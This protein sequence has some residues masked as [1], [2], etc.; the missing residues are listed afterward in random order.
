MEKQWV[1]KDIPESENIQELAEAIQVDEA[2]ATILV[3]RQIKNYDQAKAFFRPSLDRLPDP[4]L[5]KD[6][7]K[8]LNRLLKAISQQELIL[9]YGDY[10]V[11]GTTAVALVYGFLKDHY[12]HLI[13]YLPDRHTEGY[14]LSKIGI[15]WAKAQDTTLIITL[16]CGIKAIEEITYANSLAIDVIVCDHHVPGEELPPAWAILNPQQAECTY[17]YPHL[18]GCGIGFKFLQAFVKNQDLSINDLYYH[19][20]LVVLSIAADIVPIT[21]ENR[22]LAFYGLR[23]LNDRE[24]RPGLKALAEAA[25]LDEHKALNIND[26]VFKIA[27]RINSVGRLRHAKEALQMLLAEDPKEAQVFAHLLNEVNIQRKGMDHR[28]TQEALALI[29]K[30]VKSTEDPKSTVLFKEDWHKGILGIVAARCIEKY[31][32]PTIILT[33]HQDPDLITGSGR[34]IRDINLYE[35]LQDCDDL[36]IQYG[37]HQQAAGLTLKKEDLTL[38]KEKFEEAIQKRMPERPSMP[39]LEVD[40]RLDLAQITPKFWR[41]L[42]QFAPFGPENRRPVFLSEELEV[43]SPRM[44]GEKH[45]KFRVR[46]ADTAYL[47]VVAFGFGHYYDE[48]IDANLL[49]LCYTLEERTYQGKNTLQLL[50]KDIQIL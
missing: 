3:Q 31:Y 41:I 38:F 18:S 5:M 28:H 20:D 49:N 6:M 1:I 48:L 44:I 9:I 16:D 22:I 25:G 26:L 32:R 37:G 33:Q 24:L 27:P 34:S 8:A 21:D 47:E 7:D 43:V 23:L 39:I 10:D 15:D 45:V 11:D 46:Q 42:K 36:L 35:A 19:L 40:L 2:L 30:E 14:G 17:P 12:P 13:Y 4:F 29:K 50:A